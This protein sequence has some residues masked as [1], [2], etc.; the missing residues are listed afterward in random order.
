MTSQTK[1]AL[2]DSGL[3]KRIAADEQL[4]RFLYSK[5]YNRQGVKPAALMP[6]PDGDTSVFRTNGVDLDGEKSLGE[7][8]RPKHALRGIAHIVAQAVAETGLRVE[9]SEPPVR[10]ANITGW[11]MNPDDPADQKAKQKEQALL[12]AK[13]VN[14]ENGFVKLS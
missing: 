11:P 9:A 3:T 14:A 2:L 6:A 1:L 13:A 7:K 5:S 8:M 10:H 12:L 4:S